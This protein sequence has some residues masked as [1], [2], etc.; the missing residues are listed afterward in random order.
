MYHN[1]GTHPIHFA[2]GKRVKFCRYTYGDSTHC[3][4]RLI[5]RTSS[6][7]CLILA[8]D[9]D[10]WIF[11]NHLLPLLLNR[12]HRLC[13]KLVSHGVW[14]ITSLLLEKE[15]LKALEQ[16]QCQ[17]ASLLISYGKR[18]SGPA[19]TGNVMTTVIPTTI[20]R[21]S[22][23]FR[24]FLMYHLLSLGVEKTLKCQRKHYRR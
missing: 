10:S 17:E 2:C 11:V 20:A 4:R 12:H 9:E 5:S 14:T 1:Y 23:A 24:L 21:A 16:A 8:N 7:S 18:A 19:I 15:T 13:I 6:L 3:K 22:R